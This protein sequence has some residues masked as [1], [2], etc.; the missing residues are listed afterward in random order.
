MKIA[1]LISAHTDATHLARL[2]GAL[3]KDAEFF[4][5]IDQKVDVEPF[6]EA[7]KGANVHFIEHRVNV[8]WGSYRQLEY[9]MALLHAARQQGHYDYYVTLSGLDYPIWPAKKIFRYLE[10]YTPNEL[11]QGIDISAQ[12]IGSEPW[13]L[14][15]RH[16]FLGTKPWKYGTLGS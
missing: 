7:V 4:V 3:D 1:Y 6:R 12:R 10:D 9:Q 15:T 11:L 16:R 14:Y 2:I 13:H 5:H 8:V